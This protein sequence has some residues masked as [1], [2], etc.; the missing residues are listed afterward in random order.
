MQK[1]SKHVSS[2]SFHATTPSCPRFGRGPPA[3]RSRFDQDHNL[4]GTS[5]ES[6][7]GFQHVAPLHHHHTT[8]F[9]SLTQISSPFHSTTAQLHHQ[10]VLPGS[11]RSFTAIRKDA[12]LYC[13]S[14]LRSGEMFAYVGRNQNLKDLKGPNGAAAVLTPERSE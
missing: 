7:A 13:G 3:P 10:H 2:F 6:S 14:R 1:P 4:T 12:G 5:V 9:P 11:S 8:E